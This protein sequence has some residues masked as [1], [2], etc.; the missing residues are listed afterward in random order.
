M[1]VKING[2]NGITFNDG[3]LQQSAATGKNLIINGDMRIDQRNAGASVTI[4]TNSQYTIDRFQ[5]QMSQASKYSVQ[6][7]TDAPAKFNDSLKVTSASAYTVLATDFFAVEQ[8]VE[9]YNAARLNWGTSDAQTV[10][11]S[12]WVKSSLTGTFTA[13]LRNGAAN[14]SFPYTYT[15]DSANTWEYKTITIA[16]DTSGTWEVTNDKAIRVNFPLGMGTNFTSGTNSGSTGAWQAGN[17]SGVNGAVNV[18]STSGATFYLTGVQLEVGS[19]AT[20]FEHLMFSQQ[21]AMCKRYYEHSYP[22]GTVA[23]AA[24]AGLG[25]KHIVVGLTRPNNYGIETVFY[26]VEKRAT[27]TVVLYTYGGLA[28]SISNG[29]SGAVIATADAIQNSTLG[30]LPRQTGGTTLAAQAYIYQYTANSEL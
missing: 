29:D 3:S 26:T 23:G 22:Y 30:F 24:N 2:T 9:G 13:S 28:G 11:L 19:T 1:S 15:I 5:G 20:D 18:V 7:V 4:T 25:A 6:Q 16:G 8:R 14:R 27:P 17:Y 12:F 21:L 10:T